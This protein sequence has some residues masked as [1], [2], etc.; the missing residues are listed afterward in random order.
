MGEQGISHRLNHP[1]PKEVRRND[2]IA[3]DVMH[4]SDIGQDRGEWEET[5]WLLRFGSDLF[6]PRISRTRG[7][8]G[9]A[10]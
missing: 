9:S 4:Y 7:N 8:H 2:E 6:V 10:K 1:R 3:C 5:K